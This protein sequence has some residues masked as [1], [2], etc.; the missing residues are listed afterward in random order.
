MFALAFDPIERLIAA[1]EPHV[2]GPVGVAAEPEGSAYFAGIIRKSNDGLALH[3]DFAPYQA[4]GYMVDRVDAQ[5]AWNL[6]VEAP[7]EGGVT[8]LHDAAWTWS[9]SRPGEVADNYPLPRSAV[10][11]AR[12]FSFKPEPGEAWLFNTRNP[13]EVSG[14]RSAGDRIAIACFVGRL[15]DGSLV[16]W[17]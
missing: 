14:V 3:A 9:R 7:A 15:P 13:H 6:Y 4:P 17:S 11:G 16:L 1:L 10:D 8:T 12:T 5:L 2:D